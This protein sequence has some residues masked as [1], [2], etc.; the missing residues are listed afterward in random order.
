MFVWLLLRVSDYYLVDLISCFK[1]KLVI[2]LINNSVI[3]RAQ[4]VIYDLSRGV[5]SEELGLDIFAVL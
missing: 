1:K 4:A 3:K 5:V 2:N